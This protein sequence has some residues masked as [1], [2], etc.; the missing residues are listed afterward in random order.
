MIGIITVEF[1]QTNIE[2]RYLTTVQSVFSPSKKKRKIVYNFFR[3]KF[4]DNLSAVRNNFEFRAYNVTISRAARKPANPRG[5][6][7]SKNIVRPIGHAKQRRRPRDLRSCFP[8]VPPLCLHRFPL[9]F[10][11]QCRLTSRQDRNA[12]GLS[13]NPGFQDTWRRSS[14]S[15]AVFVTRFPTTGYVSIT[16]VRPYAYQIS[17]QHSSSSSSSSFRG[18]KWTLQIYETIR[19]RGN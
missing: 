6:E 10:P 8:F 7:H 19:W 12:V 2:Y 14:C 13:A 3:T 1:Y 18:T 16:C 11:P 4:F 17:L 9:P 5:I 15:N